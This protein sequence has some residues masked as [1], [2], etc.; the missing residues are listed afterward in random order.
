MGRPLSTYLVYAWI[1]SGL[2][3]Y[4]C[5]G[6]PDKTCEFPEKSGAFVS[7]DGW[8]GIQMMF[9]ILNI[10]FAPYMQI[11]V[12]NFIME[13]VKR[14]GAPIDKKTGKQ[15]VPKKDVQNA[16]KKVFCEDFGVLFYFISKREGQKWAGGILWG[17]ELK[18]D[19]SIDSPAYLGMAMFSLAF[20]YTFCWYCCPCCARAIE[21][22]KQVREQPRQAA[23]LRGAVEI[24][25]ALALSA[26]GTAPLGKG[27]VSVDQE[28]AQGR[29]HSCEGYDEEWSECP[30][31]PHCGTCKPVDCKF[32]EWGEWYDGGGCMGLKF[33][34][35]TIKVY[36][37]ECGKPCSGPKKMSVPTP[38]DDQ[39]GRAGTPCVFSSWSEWSNCSSDDDQSMRSRA[40][41]KPPS[42]GGQ[43]CAGGVKETRA[44]GPDPQRVD[45]S[46]T[47][48][49]DWTSCSASCGTGRM[50]RL[51]E[52]D[53]KA[54]HGGATCSDV[55]LQVTS[56]SG[57]ECPS[58]DCKV[59]AWSEWSMC[60]E[61]HPQRY[62]H[63]TILE[64]PSGDGSPCSEQLA[65]TQGC[66]RGGP[67]DC[68]LGEWTAWSDCTRIWRHASSTGSGSWR[69]R[70][71]GAATAA[72][73]C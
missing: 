69:L 52:V 24:S 67:V 15:V 17:S 23:P 18:G 10:V 71:R 36:N 44:C 61:D 3:I 47:A 34:D 19:C 53:A 59:S 9:A 8:R 48:W 22:E 37:N 16:F 31:V 62:R 42:Q 57:E 12:W 49:Q 21:M 11:K 39:C 4:F 56:C 13:E 46:F 26:S 58:R 40:V 1:I 54:A 5:I 55:L 73:R 65:E 7:L 20:V 35:R 41:E 28:P 72:R 33:R 6:P 32:H 29:P 51:R 60:D 43:P 50:S 68:L 25:D 27:P 64:A 70:A 2:E 63:R 14:G 38:L 30:D 66:P 45:C